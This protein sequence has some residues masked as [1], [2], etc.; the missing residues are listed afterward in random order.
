MFGRVLEYQCWCSAAGSNAWVG[1]H[2]RKSLAKGLS[3]VATAQAVVK[4]AI[5]LGSEDNVGAALAARA[6]ACA[7]ACAVLST[8]AS[9]TARPPRP[10][11]V[12][13]MVVVLGAEDWDAKVS[14]Q[15]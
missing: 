5:K 9:L 8:A 2:V 15:R 13:A 3:P 4:Q 11:Q 10:R 12:T 7:C 1:A 6:C 14:P